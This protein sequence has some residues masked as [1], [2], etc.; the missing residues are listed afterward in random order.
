MHAGRLPGGSCGHGAKSG[1]GEEV[2]EPSHAARGTAPVAHLDRVLAHGAL[3]GAGAVVAGR[4]APP[5]RSSAAISAMFLGLTVAT[6]AGVPAGTWFGQQFGWR[7]PFWVI[8]G[9][10]LV[11]VAVVAGLVPAGRAG[12]GLD[13]VRAELRAVARPIVLAGLAVT[14]LGWAGVFAVFTYIAPLVTELAGL[15]AGAVPAVLVLL[16]AG[17]WLGGRWADHALGPAVVGSLVGLTAVLLLSAPLFHSA[18]GA[19]IAAFL[20]GV[21]MFTTAAPFQ[22][23]VLRGAAGAKALASALNIGAFNAGN[24]AGAWI[25]GVV[26][27]H[28]GT[29]AALPFWAAG[30]SGLGLLLALAVTRPAADQPAP[31]E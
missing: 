27:D 29:L 19:V 24:A 10:G 15:P 14:A 6:V 25:G 13:D 12:G 9:I 22:S 18:V 26:L 2:D 21:A 11:A 20:F 1:A 30:S 8:A 23:F 5:G 16:G 31:A 3:F 4:L 17:N 28:G 7:V